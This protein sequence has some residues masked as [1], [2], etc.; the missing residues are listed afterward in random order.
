FLMPPAHFTYRGEG[1]EEGRKAHEYT[2]DV[3]PEHSSYK[4]RSGS[5]ESAVGFQG[6]FLIDA[7]SLDLIRLEAQAYDIP[8]RLG[9]AEV[10]TTL[11]YSRVTVDAAEV[12]LPVS[13]TLSVATVD[14]I[15]SLNRTRLSA[16]RH[17]RTEST[18]VFQGDP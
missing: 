5:A 7:E 8:E 15:E 4:L 18:I 10:N 3:P 17:Y 14:G 12:L 13:A 9:L 6:A 11:V 2:Y 16:C 1:E